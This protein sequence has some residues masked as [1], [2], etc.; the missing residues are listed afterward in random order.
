MILASTLDASS[1]S[2]ASNCRMAGSSNNSNSSN[3]NVNSSSSVTSAGMCQVLDSR[4]GR[5][6]TRPCGKVIA[7]SSQWNYVLPASG[8]TTGG[9]GT[10]QQPLD[11]WRCTGCQFKQGARAEGDRG[12][13]LL[14][15]WPPCAKSTANSNCH[16][17]L[18]FV[19][20]VS[21]CQKRAASNCHTCPKTVMIL[22]RVIH[23]EPTPGCV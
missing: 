5:T 8:G 12:Q 15:V 14:L 3:S 20:H 18:K 11:F 10:T 22:S 1:L 6:T 9:A 21:N 7:H 17:C 2:V 13:R 19:V 4:T 23:H 16:R